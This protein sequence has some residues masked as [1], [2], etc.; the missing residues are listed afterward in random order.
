MDTAEIPNNRKR[1]VWTILC[2]QI[3]QPRRNGQVSR[4]MQPTKTESRRSR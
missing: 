1:I 2:Q 4:Y 3:G